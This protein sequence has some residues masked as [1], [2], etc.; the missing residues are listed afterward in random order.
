MEYYTT[1]KTDITAPPYLLKWKTIYD[2]Q[3]RK[4]DPR[5]TLAMTLFH[6]FWCFLFFLS[7]HSFIKDDFMLRLYHVRSPIL[8]WLLPQSSLLLP[9][10]Y[11]FLEEEMAAHSSVLAWRIPGTG[12]PGGLLS[13]GSHRVGH[14]WSDL[15]AAAAMCKL[16]CIVSDV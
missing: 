13:M 6:I 7:D 8:H 16:L 10:M 15:A 12:E 2:N 1:R 9:V 4:A 11:K 5:T 14:D 3:A